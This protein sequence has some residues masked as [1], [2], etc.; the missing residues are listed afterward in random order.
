M[1][2]DQSGATAAGRRAQGRDAKGRELTYC[3]LC[4]GGRTGRGTCAGVASHRRVRHAGA[5]MTGA[6]RRL[7]ARGDGHIHTKSIERASMEF[8]LRQ[9]QTMACHCAGEIAQ[10]TF[11]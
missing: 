9:N 4:G 5:R 3:A 11:Q 7:G 8:D 1:R 10:K 6:R 2:A